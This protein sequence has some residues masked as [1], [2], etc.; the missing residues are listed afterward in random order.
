M[1]DG[2]LFIDRA[3]RDVWL[4]DSFLYQV[5]GPNKSNPWVTVTYQA[6]DMCDPVMCCQRWRG[7]H[8][9]YGA[10]LSIKAVNGTAIYNVGKPTAWGRWEATRADL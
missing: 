4:E 1:V 10:I 7:G 3:D 9:F 2:Q 5:A 6:F 8:C